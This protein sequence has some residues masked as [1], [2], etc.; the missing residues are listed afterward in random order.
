MQLCWMH[1]NYTSYL[2]FYMYVMN[3]GMVVRKAGHVTKYFPEINNSATC[4]TNLRQIYDLFNKSI[5]CG[6]AVQQIYD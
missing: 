5:C 1:D 4:T 6:F 3:D 2:T